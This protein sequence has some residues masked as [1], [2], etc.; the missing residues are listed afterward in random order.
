MTLPRN[1]NRCTSTRTSACTHCLHC[2]SLSITRCAIAAKRDKSG[3]KRPRRS[4]G[5]SNRVTP[6]KANHDRS[7]PLV[8]TLMD[9]GVDSLM[10]RFDAAAELASE[11]S[12]VEC[13]EVEEKDQP[14][15][16][17]TTAAY[18]QLAGAGCRD[19]WRWLGFFV[20]MNCSQL[21]G[22]CERQPSTGP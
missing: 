7:A 14:R 12:T 1:I 20:S 10:N 15:G 16:G 2:C 5:A 19:R 11:A 17:C 9:P 8:A 21:S 22:I 4:L 18:V 3:K 6:M 13:I